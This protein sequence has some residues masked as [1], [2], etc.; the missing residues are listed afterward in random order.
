MHHS[1]IQELRMKLCILASKWT[2]TSPA[3]TAFNYI[4]YVAGDRDLCPDLVCTMCCEML[5]QF[6]HMNQHSCET[7]EN[8]SCLLYTSPSPRD[9]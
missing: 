1:S 5:D 7:L 3:F 6:I 8:I 4:L 2:N 9:S